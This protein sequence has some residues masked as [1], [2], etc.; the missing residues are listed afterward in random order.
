MGSRGPVELIDPD[1]GT[2][3]PMGCEDPN[4]G[5]R[6]PHLGTWGP[7][8]GTL[9][10]HFGGPRDHVTSELPPGIRTRAPPAALSGRSSA[11]TH[12]SAAPRDVIRARREEADVIRARREEADVISARRAGSAVGAAFCRGVLSSRGVLSRHGERVGH[13]RGEHDADRRGGVPAMAGRP[14]GCDMSRYPYPFPPSPHPP[15]TPALPCWG[16]AIP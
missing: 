5:T 15:Q 8:L 1:I 10:C 16:V 2:W 12:A 3:G 9:R 13:L 7:H 6:G 4:T 14:L 11:R